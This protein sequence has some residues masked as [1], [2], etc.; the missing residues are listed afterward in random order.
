MHTV[1]ISP[2]AVSIGTTATV[3]LL[4]ELVPWSTRRRLATRTATTPRCKTVEWTT[5]LVSTRDT[6]SDS[7]L[8]V[9]DCGMD[10]A[11][12]S[13]STR[14][15]VKRN[16]EPAKDEKAAK[17]KARHLTAG[18]DD[19]WWADIGAAFGGGLAKT[20]V[21]MKAKIAAAPKED[22]KVAAKKD[23]KKEPAKDEKAAK[24]KA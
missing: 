17:K 1:A 4:C 13:A 24:K 20:A 7:D 23:E 22:A 18:A 19:Q 16:T 2:Q 11:P 8:A 9:A 15:A 6:D 21:E 12:Y 3:T 14:S 10:Y 5:Y